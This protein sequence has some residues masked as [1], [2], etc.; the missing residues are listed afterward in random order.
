MRTTLPKNVVHGVYLKI[1]GPSIP[2][3]LSPTKNC[4]ILMLNT[5]YSIEWDVL[6][7]PVFYIE[8]RIAK[9]V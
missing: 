6:K 4:V 1:A 9:S 7:R 8:A 2:I 3:F 5:I